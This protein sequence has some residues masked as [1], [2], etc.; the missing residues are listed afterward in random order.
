M[1]ADSASEGVERRL[2]VRAWR[3]RRVQLGR[4]PKRAVEVEADRLGRLGVA[5][6]LA[7]WKAHT[8]LPPR[9]TFPSA[10][11]GEPTTFPVVNR[12]SSIPVVALSVYTV[13][14]ELT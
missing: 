8:A 3:P 14:T 1:A 10:T 6:P 11:T 7:R 2:E 5:S 4:D 13:S 9:Y 12:D